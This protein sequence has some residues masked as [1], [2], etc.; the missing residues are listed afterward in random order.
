MRIG[1]AVVVAVALLLV[2]AS[3]LLLAGIVGYFLVSD[4]QEAHLGEVSSTTV[5]PA[6][7]TSSSTTIPVPENT[8][9]KS[10]LASTTSSTVPKTL[11]IILSPADVYRG[12]YVAVS[13][14]DDG[15]NPRAGAVVTVDGEGLGV[16]DQQGS[17]LWPEAR[18][19]THVVEAS[20]AGFEDVSL[21]VV[22]D[23]SRYGQSLAARRLL[24]DGER[25]SAIGKGKASVRFYETPTCPNCRRVKDA[26]ADIVASRRNCVELEIINLWNY[27]EELEGRFPVMVTPIIEIEGAERMVQMNG[28]VSART[29]ERRIDEAMSGA[30]A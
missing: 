28:L 17:L 29:L 27:R 30:C 15:G 4:T 18:P 26:L 25:Q 22:V 16:A 9:T 20:L 5:T 14:E 23:E 19:G 10:S 12:D 2:A 24:S 1:N 21:E 6:S 8:T 13:V 7:T 11:N 3:L